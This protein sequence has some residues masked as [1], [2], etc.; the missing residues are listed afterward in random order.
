MRRILDD[1][2]SPDDIKVL[3]YEEMDRLAF[4]IRDFI[5]K[6]VADTGGHL[7]SN[8]GVVE[9]TLALHYHLNSPQDKIIWDVG[10]QSYI[11][12]IIT[13]RKNEFKTIRQYEGLSG[14]PKRSESVHDIIET[15]HSSTS[16]GSALGLALARDHEQRKDRVYAVIGDGSLTAGMAFEALN[17]A[18]HLGRDMTVILN[19]N[20]MSISPNV[21]ALS[22]YLSNIR[23]D[24]RLHKLKEDIEFIISRIPRIGSVM[25]RT[26]ERVKDGLKYTVLTGILFEEMGFTYIGPLNGHNIEELLNNFKKAD[27]IK[28]PVLIHVNTIKGKGYQPAENQPSKYHGVSPFKIGN[29][30]RKKERALPSYSEVFGRAMIKIGQ[31]DN[32]LIGI[33]AAMPEGTGLNIFKE[34]FSDRFYD[35]GIAEQHAV[36]LATGL[37]RGGKKP[38]VAIYSS[39]LQRAYD[40]IIHD[41]C[42]QNLPVVFAIDRSGIVG[43]DGETHQ[44]TFDISFLRPIPNLTLMAPKDENE[45][46]H[47]LYTAVNLD[48]PAAIRYPRGDI[49]GVKIDQDLN[50]LEVGKAEV[51]KEGKDI[52][53]IA[54]GSR[55]YP[56]LEAARQLAEQ[57]IEAEVINARFIKPLDKDLLVAKIKKFKKVVTVEEQVLN[58]G[59]GTA[60][61]ELINKEQLEGISL[62]RLGLP[63]SFIPHGSQEMMRSLYGIDTSG[64]VD[65]V[66]E[67]SAT[68]MG[69][70]VWPRKNA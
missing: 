6:T 12:K 9:L 44:G 63:D 20:N 1:V 24:P 38:V 3:S 15:G 22:H 27:M 69:V 37:A 31:L 36:T 39:F 59:F 18:G 43:N 41:T 53:I 60:V 4:E 5:I 2:Y 70:A 45:L 32:D 58:G 64:I 55:V 26:I 21:G 50:K 49:Y 7:A 42:I 54:I 16:I 52:L 25:S 62:K 67:F 40:Q 61:L 51:V 10:H 66:L 34:K 28:G 8:L 47:M 35:V 19:D 57:G 23:I 65:T 13:G 11:H 30:E 29:G 46:Q 48:S 56:S 14:Y 17:H 68:D 33:T